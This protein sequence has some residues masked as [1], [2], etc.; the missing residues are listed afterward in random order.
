MNLISRASSGITLAV[1]LTV[2]AGCSGDTAVIGRDPLP[3]R[4]S[5]PAQNELVATVE[6]LNTQTGAIHLQPNNGG[7][8]MVTYN[9]ETR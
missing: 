3:V 6:G 8:E 9:A 5:Q 2:S 7:R 1:V 4:P